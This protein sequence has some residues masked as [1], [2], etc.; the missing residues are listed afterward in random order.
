MTVRQASPAADRDAAGPRAWAVLAACLLAVFMQMLD[1]TIV[2][3]ALPVLARQLSA[4]GSTQLLVVT[5]Y[6]VAFACALL[7]AARLGDQFG[8]GR[9]FL[10]GMAVFTAASLGCALAGNPVELVAGRVAQGL[11]A[12]AVAA[13][14]IA[15]LAAAFPAH[16]R[17]LA[18][19]IY[20]AVAGLAGLSGP[21]LGG[22]IVAADPG[23]LGWRAI[24]LLNLPLGCAALVLAGRCLGA[25]RRDRS[26]RL[27]L[28]GAALS[29][30]GLLMVL[31]PLA[32]V[33]NS[34]WSSTM[35]GSVA[36]GVALLAG[37][38]RQ[39]WRTAT[40]GGTPMISATVCGDRTFGIGALALLA[41]YGL[42]AALLLTVS[43][44]AQS[45]LNWSAWQTGRFMLPFAAGALVA[46]LTSPILVRYWGTRTLTVGSAAFAVA[47]ALLAFTIHP[48]A[49]GID[50]RVVSAPVLLAG[51]GMGWFAAPLPAIMVA[52]LDERATGTASGLAPTVQQLG[53][54]IGATMLGSLFFARVAGGSGVGHAQSVLARDLGMRAI[55]ADERIATVRRFTECAHT[56]F[57]AP[58]HVLPAS[59]C[60]GD[61]AVSALATAQTFLSACVTVLWIVSAVAGGLA[62]VT[63]ALPRRPG[64]HP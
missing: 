59:G 2:N 38:A 57:V 9:L 8:R 32:V 45:G 6:S 50:A 42:F 16:R 29:T 53:S 41:F 46:A 12:A 43:V 25:G 62:V 55:P 54:A 19:G 7:T 61:H 20:G 30:S 22:L 28:A 23:G 1:L 37:F 10:I 35:I 44:T 64:G 52:G 14:T 3:T 18:F 15:I 60:G 5:G 24:F 40:G 21:M 48:A 47:M 39:Q 11:G 36:L 58:A 17:P 13:Q 33:G 63:L 31:Y 51:C 56:A 49:G 4:G 26:V 27:D 34:G